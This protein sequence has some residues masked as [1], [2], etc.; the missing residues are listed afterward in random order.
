MAWMA[1]AVMNRPTTT[2][3]ERCHQ[4]PVGITGSSS[5]HMNICPLRTPHPRPPVRHRSLPGSTGSSRSGSLSPGRGGWLLGPGNRAVSFEPCAGRYRGAGDDGSG[6][7]HHVRRD[8]VGLSPPMCWQRS[9]WRVFAQTGQ[10]IEVSVSHEP[11]CARTTD[12]RI[13]AGRSMSTCAYSVACQ[14]I[15]Y[16]LDDRLARTV[17]RIEGS[18]GFGERPHAAR[19]RAQT[20]ITGPALRRTRH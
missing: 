8:V 7:R 1:L 19:R 9:S 3:F 14:I 18:D 10:T 6:H 13:H 2:R 20:A 17:C 16:D 15:C 4:S 5:I 11:A 12:S